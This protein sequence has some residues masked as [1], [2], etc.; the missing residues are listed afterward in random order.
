MT[1][2]DYRH[3]LD[4]NGWRSLAVD[5]TNIVSNTWPVISKLHTR[6][7]S[8]VT[9]F[10]SHRLASLVYLPRNFVTIFIVPENIMFDENMKQYVFIFTKSNNSRASSKTEL[11]FC[12]I[13]GGG[14]PNCRSN[15]Q[16]L[17]VYNFGKITEKPCFNC[18]KC[19]V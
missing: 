6:H 3:A 18:H 7:R 16:K 1:L 8:C 4:T 12:P 10:S 14:L 19:W 13:V 17:E 5:S 11:Q 2:S 15:K 9:Q